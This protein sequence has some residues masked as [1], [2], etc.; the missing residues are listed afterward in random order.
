MRGRGGAEN[1]TNIE[2]EPTK[3]RGDRQRSLGNEEG[4]EVKW[5][6][7][8]DIMKMWRRKDDRK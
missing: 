6:L 5:S 2:A 8:R 4:W 3:K 7:D 1:T